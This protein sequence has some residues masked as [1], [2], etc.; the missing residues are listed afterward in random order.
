MQNN[1][2]NSNLSGLINRAPGFLLFSMVLSF[3]IMF[4]VQLF[5]YAEIF[6]ESLPSIAFSYAIGVGMGLMYQLSRLALGLAGAYEFSRGKIGI[7]I[8]GLAFSFGLTLFESFEV[9]EMAVFWS[10][11]NPL[12]YNSISIGLQAVIWLGFVLEVR[13]A[14]SIGRGVRSSVN[15]PNGT[16]SNSI[17]GNAA[18]VPGV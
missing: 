13:L 5:Y 15:F 10:A 7:G 6:S 17:T 4:V 18:S 14:L 11:E 1:D 16:Q 8:A 9:T 2:F 3:V 12:I